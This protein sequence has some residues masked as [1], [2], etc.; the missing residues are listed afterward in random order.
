MASNFNL[1]KKQKKDVNDFDDDEIED[2]EFDDNS[3]SHHNND[4]AK[5]RL[6]KLM[7]IIVVFTVV[8]LFFL[9]I[10][11]LVGGKKIT[12]EDA[13]EI[14]QQAAVD[15]FADHKEYLPQN[16]GDIVE[17]GVDNLVLEGKMKDLS[18]YFYIYHI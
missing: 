12:Y 13:E 10:A 18:T 3:S 8:L 9:W 1:V 11:S 7:L 6:I 4:D 17:V 15:Y 2:I 16:D 5:A 14:M